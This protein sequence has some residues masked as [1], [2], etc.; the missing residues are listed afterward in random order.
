MLHVAGITEMNN[1]RR[2]FSS[3]GPSTLPLARIAC[4]GAADDLIG[5]TAED[6]P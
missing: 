1:R 6:K 4:S 2:R 5:D 3:S